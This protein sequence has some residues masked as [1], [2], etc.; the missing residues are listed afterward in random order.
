MFYFS[1]SHAKPETEEDLKPMGNK[2]TFGTA[3]LFI[4]VVRSADYNVA[5]E[6]MAENRLS[7]NKTERY[8]RKRLTSIVNINRW[9]NHQSFLWWCFYSCTRVAWLQYL[10]QLLCP[11]NPQSMLLFQ[12]W[13]KRWSI[14]R[15]LG[16]LGISWDYI[17][18]LLSKQREVT[19]ISGKKWGADTS[20]LLF[21][22][23]H[24]RFSA[25]QLPA[26]VRW[27]KGAFQIFTG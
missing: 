10:K 8:G 5:E 17:G 2:E 23:G 27:A 4:R 15:R 3:D 12:L 24:K 14:S 21:R 7:S 11:G 9:W 19:R 25:Y 6:G 26:W 22:P 16:V 1:A 13:V 18:C 20:L